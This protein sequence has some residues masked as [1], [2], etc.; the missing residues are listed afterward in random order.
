MQVS[1]VFILKEGNVAILCL[2]AILLCK[3][4]FTR[5]QVCVC[6]KCHQVCDEIGYEALYFTCR[7][8]C[9]FFVLDLHVCVTELHCQYCFIYFFYLP[10]FNKIFIYLFL[11]PTQQEIRRH[12]PQQQKLLTMTTVELNNVHGPPLNSKVNNN[13][14]VK[15]KSCYFSFSSIEKVQWYMYLAFSL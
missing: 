5:L 12:L 1:K 3:S 4:I 9:M 8:R 7:Y 14:L 6:L 15:C 11:A 2:L 10:V 13:Y